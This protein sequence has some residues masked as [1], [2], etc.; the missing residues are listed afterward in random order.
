MWIGCTKS[1]GSL[2]LLLLSF[3]CIVEIGIQRIYF[4]RVAF[5][6][7]RGAQWRP[8]STAVIHVMTVCSDIASS[9]LHSLSILN[10]RRHYLPSVD[11][12]FST[13]GMSWV[14]VF[15]KL[16]LYY[17]WRP[18]SMFSVLQSFDCP[19]QNHWFIYSVLESRLQYSTLHLSQQ[20]SKLT[21]DRAISNAT[22]M[23]SWEIWLQ[24]IVEI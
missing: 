10:D 1:Y 14:F 12:L 8:L 22:E 15:V 6:D 11:G 9:Y 13:F 19:V 3:P 18:V 16:W 20:D 5:L 2:C 4:K 17:I 24:N 7:T 21:K 23:Y